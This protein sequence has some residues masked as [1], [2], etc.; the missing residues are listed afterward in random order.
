MVL[1]DSRPD[2]FIMLSDQGC[3]TGLECDLL[4]GKIYH[5]GAGPD[6]PTE[7]GEYAGWMT[8]ITFMAS[9][10]EDCLNTMLEG[11]F[12]DRLQAGRDLSDEDFESFIESS[13]SDDPR[14]V[15]RGLYRFSPG[16]FP[17]KEPDPEEWDIDE[18]AFDLPD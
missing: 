8:T 10:L 16:F 4:T 18:S 13:C 7:D 5:T 11:T 3:G 9:S 17:L 2:G 6:I 12:Y 1:S 14:N 15:W